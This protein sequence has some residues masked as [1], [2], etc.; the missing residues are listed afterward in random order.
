LLVDGGAADGGVA[1]IDWE[2]C[3]ARDALDDLAW[4]L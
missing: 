1:W 2:H 4:L 3:G